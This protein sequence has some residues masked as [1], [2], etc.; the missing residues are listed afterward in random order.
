MA[1][2]DVSLRPAEAMLGTFQIHNRI[3]LYLLENL[4]PEAWGMAPP[5]AARGERWRRWLFISTV[6]S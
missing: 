5:E 3:N 2:K 6:C 1:G 4:A